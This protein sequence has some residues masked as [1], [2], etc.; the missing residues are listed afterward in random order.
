MLEAEE[1]FLTGSTTLLR[2]VVRV[3]AHD[4]GAG[5][6]GPVTKKLMEAFGLLLDKECVKDERPRT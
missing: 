2:P 6:P 3:E 5:T 1:I 4:V